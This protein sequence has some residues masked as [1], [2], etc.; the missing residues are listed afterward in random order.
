VAAAQQFRQALALL[1]DPDMGGK[2][3]DLRTLSSASWTSPWRPRRR[4]PKRRNRRWRAGRCRFPVDLKR[5]YTML[6]TQVSPPI[7]VRQDMPR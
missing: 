7:A 3:P 6:D 4:R 2:L 5:T 1:S